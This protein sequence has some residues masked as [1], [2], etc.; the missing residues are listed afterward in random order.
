[1]REQ[2]RAVRLRTF[3]DVEGRWLV[4][5][6][7]RLLVYRR[8]MWFHARRATLKAKEMGWIKELP[9]LRAPTSPEFT[10]AARERVKQWLQQGQDKELS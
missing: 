3:A 2:L 7:K 1:M 8:V 9:D 5:E 4:P 6:G 10:Q